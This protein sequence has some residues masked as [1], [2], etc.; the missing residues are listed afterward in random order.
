M[1]G[2]PVS[3]AE[4]VGVDYLNE[5]VRA[6]WRD[7]TL[8]DLVSSI[9]ETDLIGVAGTGIAIPANTLGTQRVLRISILGDLFNNSGVNGD[10]VTFK[11]YYGGS[12]VAAG[13]LTQTAGTN[14]GSVY[15]QL[16]V[17]AE[18]ATNAQ[19]VEGFAWNDINYV[20]L[21][22]V[23]ATKGW[24]DLAIDDTVAQNLRV[25]ATLNA[26]LSTLEFRKRILLVEVV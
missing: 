13:L 12:S 22:A 25:T 5:V 16:F 11:V 1:T 18:G 23:N 15:A 21:P 26:N 9:T 14:R 19:A 6:H 8:V 4:L 24:T 3:V 10:G 7:T 20:P 17:S 2:L